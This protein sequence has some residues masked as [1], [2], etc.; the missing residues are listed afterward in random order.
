MDERVFGSAERREIAGRA[1]TLQ[2]RLDGPPNVDAGQPPLDPES[3]LD[4]WQSLFPSEQAFEARLDEQGLSRDVVAEQVAAT[5]WPADE[6][7]PDWLDRLEELVRYVRSSDGSVGADVVPASETVAFEELLV[8]IAAYAREQ[9]DDDVV[10][11][12]AATPMLR[13]LVE[14]LEYVSSR[15]LYVEFKSYLDH[16]APELLDADPGDHEDP[17]TEQYE[18][19]VEAML[20]GGTKNL[21]LEYPVLAR[22]LV[23]LV[24]QC[25]EATTELCRRLRRDRPELSEQFAV[26]GPVTEL[27]P[28]AEDKHADGRVPVRVSFETGDVVY[29]PRS[30]AAGRLFYRVLAR[31]DDSLS[32]P[33][34][35]PPT[36]V[37]RDGYGWME[38]V[39]Y[40]DPADEAAV[41]RYYERAG[42]VLCLAYA[43]NFNDCQVE[44]LVVAGDAPVLLDGETFL[45]PEV[46]PADSPFTSEVLSLLDRSVLLT[47]LLPFSVGKPRDLDRRGLGG[48]VAGFGETSE[49]TEVTAIP[50]PRIRA[51]NTDV[52]TIEGKPSTFDR[53]F[54]TPTLDGSDR[55]PGEYVD[56][57]LRGFEEAYETIRRLHSE[58][59]FLSEV[60]PPDSVEGLPV[61]LLYR[62]TDSY[63]SVLNA[64][65]A[66]R[67][68]QDGV[69]FSVETERLV[70]PFF[71]GTVETGGYWELYEAELRAVYRRDIP[72]L[73]SR[74]DSGTAFHD[75]S[76][77]DTSLDFDPGYE[78]VRRRMDDLDRTDRRRQRW[79][80]RRS[81]RSGDPPG[82]PPAAEPV[83][84]GRL[85]RTAAELFRSA[86]AAA[87]DVNGRKVWVSTSPSGTPFS[88]IPAD[89]SLYY[90]RTGIALAAAALAR[91]RDEGYGRHVEETLAPVAERVRSDGPAFRLGG[92]LGVG[93]VVYGLAVVADLL[94]DDRYRELAGATAR[95]VTD[96]QLRSDDAYDVTEGSAGVLLGLLAYHDRFGGREVVDR[97]VACGERLLEARTRV[98][99]EG[100]RVWRGVEDTVHTGFAHGSTGIAY[101]LARLYGTTGESRFAS[102]AREALEF[103]STLYSPDRRNWPQTPAAEVYQDRWCHGRT[104]MAL[105]RIGIAQHL[106]DESL[107]EEAATALSAVAS[108]DASTS[109]HVCCGNLGRAEVL[110]VGARRGLADRSAATRLVGRCLARR[111]EEGR[112]VLK[113]H[114]AEFTNPTWFNGVCGAAYTL[115]RMSYPDVLPS[116]VRFE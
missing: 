86:L 11:V 111:D 95:A 116:V 42:V 99:S 20:D 96:E 94:E 71:D 46:A 97:A 55:P 75:R 61:R 49:P 62:S 7:L 115:L 113:G 92:T 10:P 44:N 109:D 35:D 102:A 19:F 57:I 31:V 107:L 40:R 48:F 26:E 106:G 12:D 88:L 43:L 91:T 79:L 73:G 25:V 63:V 67:P 34:F 16:Q 41:E 78:C 70:V 80:V 58:G 18:R 84:D 68:L 60:L 72:R 2:Q 33:S 32:T 74:A 29:K 103:E 112:L 37:S 90:G 22:Q 51:K 47:S 85:E 52:M 23:A 69:R 9:L 36:Y 65:S 110:A 45:H 54:N 28:L 38:T 82:R 14:H 105:G 3:V 81:L 53:E 59:T 13:W 100:H 39:E 50:R 83:T 76:R 24:D 66:R 87:Y 98:G 5:H 64:T 15:V 4:D 1:R 56:S 89:E 30:V 101:A 114:S 77:L 6:P 8:R 108:A 93:S 21:C 104:G 17:P 27:A